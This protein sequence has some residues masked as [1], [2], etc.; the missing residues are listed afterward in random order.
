MLK[1]AHNV[2]Q[3]WP[4]PDIIEDFKEHGGTLGGLLD[5]LSKFKDEVEGD[6][7]KDRIEKF[8]NEITKIRE[9]MYEHILENVYCPS[10]S[11]SVQHFEEFQ[12]MARNKGLKIKTNYMLDFKTLKDFTIPGDQLWIF[13]QRPLIRSYAHVVIIIDDEKFIHVTAPKRLHMKLIMKSKIKKEVQTKL[14]DEK[15]C[16][17]VRPSCPPDRPQEIFSQRAVG[18]NGILF[19]YDTE[20]SNCETFCNGVHGLWKTSVQG[21]DIRGGVQKGIKAYSKFTKLIKMGEESLTKQMQKKIQSEGLLLSDEIFDA[22]TAK[23]DWGVGT[24]F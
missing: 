10:Q 9:E 23:T 1:L 16:F 13:H 20:T 17:I 21:L 7:L 6:G 15:S 3:D 4:Y 12:E 14:I 22:V 2:N 24:F 5:A 8:L 11:T 18:C 19:N